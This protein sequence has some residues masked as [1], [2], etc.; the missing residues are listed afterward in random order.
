MP[1]IEARQ[2]VLQ[3][4][5]RV[6]QADTQARAL[7]EQARAAS[8]SLAKN[9]SS[10]VQ[11]RTTML[12]QKAYTSRVNAEI[13][14]VRA[15]YAL[16]AEREGNAAATAQQTLKSVK[17]SRQR[18]VLIQTSR[19]ASLRRNIMLQAGAAAEKAFSFAPP[20]PGAVAPVSAQQTTTGLTSNYRPPSYV[21]RAGDFFPADV[22]AAAGSLRGLADV[23][24]LGWLGQAEAVINDGAQK[25]LNAA[26]DAAKAV[27]A[28]EAGASDLSVQAEGLVNQLRA[29]QE[30]EAP[31]GRLPWLHIIGGGILAVVLYKVVS[32]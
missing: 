14:R 5:N 9:P 13:G 23:G 20:L 1:D 32:R 31:G 2:L 7:L 17:D 21:A 10:A 11:G 30:L 29:Q 27:T 3:Q 16:L 12:A 18:A 19:A 22:R 8:F 26:H 25:V 24:S 28:Q 15:A 6:K 4:L